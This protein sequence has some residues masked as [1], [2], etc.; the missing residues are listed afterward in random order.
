MLLTGA[1]RENMLKHYFKGKLEPGLYIKDYLKY[2]EGCSGSDIC[3]FYRYCSTN[4][5][6][7]VCMCP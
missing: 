6:L 1:T 3:T 4:L 2:T 7:C 5:I